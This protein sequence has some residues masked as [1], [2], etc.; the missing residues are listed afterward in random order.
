[1]APRNRIVIVGGGLAGLAAAAALAPRGFRVTVL[2]SRP[3][4]G[5]R[6]SSFTDQT[7]GATIDNCQ[8]VSLGC[9]TNWQH[10]C[11][12]TG[13]SEALR[14]ERRMHFIGPDGRVNRFA[15]A[16]LPAPFHLLPAFAR[17]NYLSL[18]DKWSLAWGLRALARIRPDARSSQ[19]FS[20]WLTEHGQTPATI[21]RVW[22]VV[23]VSALSETLDRID[24]Q[25]ARKVFV[26]AFLAHRDAWEMQVPAVPLDELYSGR[27]QQWL[28]GHSASVRV[29]AGV[30]RVVFREGGAAGVVLRNAEELPAEHVILAVP[31]YLVA[32]LLPDEMV[33]QLNL[34]QLEQIESAP[35]SSAHL[36]FDRPLTELPHAVFVNR[37]S[38]WVFNRAATEGA[39]EQ[40]RY[41]YQVVISASRDLR[42][43]AQ[44]DVLAEV[45]SDLALAWPAARAARLEHARLVTEHKAVI[46][47]RPGSDAW[48]PPQETSVPGLHLAG[49][50]TRTGWPSTMEGAVRSGYLAAESVLRQA[51]RPERLLEPDLPVG[52]LARLCLGIV[53][54]I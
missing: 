21:E 47:V 1:M 19:P 12:T 44:D 46:S 40:G 11:R 5:G 20:E 9:C 32:S 33:A 50:W 3:R 41:Y 37:L 17:L 13:L 2:E 4:L 18:R 29:Q 15:A 22:H 27:L 52:R 25:Q 31:H 36:W 8:H 42:G 30:G 24:V 6:A 49:D 43:R 16:P 23:L 28:E 35:I 54:G 34:S 10:F 7:T 14:W 51:G 53:P 26:D 39:D 45:V 48:R 38:Q